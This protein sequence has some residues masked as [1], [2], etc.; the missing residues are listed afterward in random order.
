[1]I[2]RL[3]RSSSQP[4]GGRGTSRVLALISGGL[5]LFGLIVI[6]LYSA[7]TPG[8]SL[9]YIGVGVLTAVAA[10][11][12]GCLLGFLF[13]I[14]KVVSTGEL[15]HQKTAPTEVVKTETPDTTV[16]TSTIPPGTVPSTSIEAAAG[17]PSQTSQPGATDTASGGNRATGSPFEPSTNLSEVSDWL[18]KLLLGAGLVQ[19]THLGKPLGKLINAV[20]F[21]LGRPPAVAT[22]DNAAQV[23]AGSLL[24]AYF[25]LGFLDGYVVTTLWYGR[26]LAGS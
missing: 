18:T 24:V 5:A 4:H 13:G 17:A 7:S 22:P 8:R 2:R 20:A 25:V 21:G 10:M 12:S 15:R 6:I 3:S 1:M 23:M 19:L 16:T 14:P 26:K 9:R 11:L